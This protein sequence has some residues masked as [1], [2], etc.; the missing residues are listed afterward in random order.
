[1]SRKTNRCLT[2]PPEKI[3][4]INPE[5][6]RLMNDFIMY[7][8]SVDRSEQT[9]VVYKNDLLIFF[10]W[11]VDNANNKFFTDISKRDIMAFQNYALGQGCSASRV[12]HLKAALSSL[13]RKSTRLNSSH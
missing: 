5:N 2:A 8:R 6:I 4:Q 12:R 13:D 7:L 11:V 10:C 3:A 1:M 9:I